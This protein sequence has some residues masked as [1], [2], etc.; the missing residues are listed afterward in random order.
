MK[1]TEELITRKHLTVPSN[2]QL[3]LKQHQGLGEP[4]KNLHVTLTPPKT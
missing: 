2:M 4:V 3:T 1:Y